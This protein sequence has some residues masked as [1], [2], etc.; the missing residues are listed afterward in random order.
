M[1]SFKRFK[2]DLII[3]YDAY[4]SVKLKDDYWLLLTSFIYYIGKNNSDR[5]VVV[6]KWFLSDGASVPWIARI[7][8]PKMGRHS[9]AA[10]LH[11]WLCENYYILEETDGIVKPVKVSRKEIDRIFCE[12]LGVLNVAKW[13]ILLIK[14]SLFLYR[15]YKNPTKP[16]IIKP[17]AELQKRYQEEET[18]VFSCECKE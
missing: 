1:S 15:L 17:K 10:F 5:Y 16:N 3:T 4:A 12:A 7:L 6:P 2:G 9:Q 18:C 14:V 8:I 13:R 11:D